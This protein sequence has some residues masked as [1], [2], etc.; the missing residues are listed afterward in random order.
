MLHAFPTFTSY[1][2]ISPYKNDSLPLFL[3][4]STFHPIPLSLS[5]NMFYS[6]FVSHDHRKFFPAVFVQH[7]I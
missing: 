6:Y 2:H 1:V 3:K 4:N 5:P 7:N